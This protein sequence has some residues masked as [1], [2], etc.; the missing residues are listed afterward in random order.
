[1]LEDQSFIFGT[2]R[3]VGRQECSNYRIVLSNSQL[4]CTLQS[5]VG[6][7]SELLLPMTARATVLCCTTSGAA[8]W[9]SC[10]LETVL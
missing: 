9:E 1:M 4:V 5:S 3:R 10:L 7:N 2:G 6:L 8:V